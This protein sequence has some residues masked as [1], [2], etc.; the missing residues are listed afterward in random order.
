MGA[1]RI[2]EEVEEGKVRDQEMTSQFA[3]DRIATLA[4][5][6]NILGA[7]N[8]WQQWRVAN[9]SGVAFTGDCDVAADGNGLFW[10]ESDRVKG[11]VFLYRPGRV[12][13]A[14]EKEVCQP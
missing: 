9:P 6:R 14:L 7:F 3:L 2:A 1:D 11:L 8:L 5:E 12:L 13:T 4:T 10:S